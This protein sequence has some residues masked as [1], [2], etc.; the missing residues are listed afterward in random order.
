MRCTVQ[1]SAETGRF[2]VACQVLALH[3]G[4]PSCPSA[5]AVA[6][7]VADKDGDTFAGHFWR[8]QTLSVIRT[9]S[10]RRHLIATSC[11]W[12]IY[13][14]E[15]RSLACLSTK[16]DGHRPIRHLRSSPASSVSVR[17]MVV[18]RG[19]LSVC[20]VRGNAAHQLCAED[21]GSLLDTRRPFLPPS[22]PCPSS[23][24]TSLHNSSFF[25]PSHVGT[26]PASVL[27]HPLASCYYL[28]LP[29]AYCSRRSSCALASCCPSV[30]TTPTQRFTT[31]SNFPEP[32]TRAA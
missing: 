3:H 8:G 5:I 32:F 12:C 2:A 31:T 28:L 27:H 21:F 24:R 4:R 17:F 10:C 11:P 7:T 22:Y 29:L 13:A 26:L 6:V 25:L 16:S 14:S 9:S 15:G 1:V 20:S 23:P 19:P 18:P 30:S